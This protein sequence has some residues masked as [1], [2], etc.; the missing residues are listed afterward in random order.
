MRSLH[1]FIEGIL[2]DNPTER[3]ARN[4][5]SLIGNTVDSVGRLSGSLL[6]SDIGKKALAAGA[7]VFLLRHIGKRIEDKEETKDTP[8]QIE[9]K[10]KQ[11]PLWLKKGVKKL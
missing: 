3:I 9:N 2:D 8:S 10:P 7:G 11:V 1:N 5:G 6:L 4:A